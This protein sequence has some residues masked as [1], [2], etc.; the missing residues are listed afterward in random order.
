MT[1]L[2][3]ALLDQLDAD[4]LRRFA[5]RL[6]PYLPHDDDEDRWLTSH[7]AAEYLGVS[8]S[9]ISKLVAARTIPSTQEVEGGRHYFRRADLDGYR[10]G[11]TR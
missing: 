9:T 4:D 3:R 7:E 5:E 11:R 1:D 10:Q 8:Y 6:A 2:G